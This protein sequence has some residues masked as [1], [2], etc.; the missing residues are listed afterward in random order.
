MSMIEVKCIDQTLTITNAPLIAS[1]DIQVD[2]VQFDF[3]STWN[4]FGKVAVFYRNDK[5]VYNVPIDEATS[6][7]IIPKEV[8]EKEGYFWFGVFGVIYD[9][10]S[11]IFKKKTSEI[12]RYKVTKGVITTGTAPPTPTPDI[13]SQILAKYSEIVGL[14]R[15]FTECSDWELDAIFNLEYEDVGKDESHETLYSE[16]V[17]ARD[18]KSS[19]GERLDNIESSIYDILTKL[20]SS[21]GDPTDVQQI[22]AEVISA[23]EGSTTLDDRL[24]GIEASVNNKISDIEIDNILEG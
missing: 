15:Y 7:C 4:N 10:N 21:G 9:E 16:V 1:G 6:I 2:E 23:R 19:L 22:L 3:C 17:D 24:D 11:N 18:G 20:P 14:G 8:L 5:E 13:Y 12:L